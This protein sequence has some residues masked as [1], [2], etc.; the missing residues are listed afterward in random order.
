MNYDSVATTPR[1]SL[2]CR[3]CQTPLRAFWQP[4]LVS[5]KPGCWLVECTNRRCRMWGQ[6]VSSESYATLDLSAYRAMKW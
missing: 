4:G 5:S 6:T 2:R 1:P 3:C